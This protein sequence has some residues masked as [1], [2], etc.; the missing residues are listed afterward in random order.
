MTFTFFLVRRAETGHSA[1]YSGWVSRMSSAVPEWS[2][3]HEISLSRSKNA[4]S[5]DGKRKEVRKR[6]Q[7]RN[8]K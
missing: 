3:K 6:W 4:W 1:A 2:E 5:M 8:R 7:N